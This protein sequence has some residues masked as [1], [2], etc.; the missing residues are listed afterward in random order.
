[1]SGL[2][3]KEAPI[4]VSQK[5]YKAAA[6]YEQEI[7]QVFV[8][9]PFSSV[10]CCPLLLCPV[11]NGCSCQRK[12]SFCRVF[13][14]AATLWFVCTV[15]VLCVLGPLLRVCSW[16]CPNSQKKA[17]RLSSECLK[18][19]YCWWAET[20]RKQVAQWFPIKICYFSWALRR[21]VCVNGKTKKLGGVWA[22]SVCW[23]YLKYAA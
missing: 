1:M 12:T 14:M 22:P 10:T 8:C 13:E 2:F 16:M 6:D 17:L 20:W 5:R 21:S 19:F 23:S 9:T 3:I 18:G 4:S 11:D 7:T 15:A